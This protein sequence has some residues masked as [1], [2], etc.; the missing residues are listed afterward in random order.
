M[1]FKSK[2]LM[3][4]LDFDLY[5]QTSAYRSGRFEENKIFIRLGRGGFTL[6]LCLSVPRLWI[7]FCPRKFQEMGVLFFGFF[8]NSPFEDVHLELSHWLDSF[9]SFYR[10]IFRWHE[11]IN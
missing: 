9:S 4:E 11:S 5:R 3:I 1:S 8:L 10:L 7:W 2:F 6:S